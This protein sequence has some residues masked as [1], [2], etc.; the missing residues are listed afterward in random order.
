MAVEI[1][2]P[3][4]GDGIAS[5]DVLNVLVKEGDQIKKDQGIIELETGKAT[6]EVP[7]THEGKIT[8]VLVAAGQTI[9]IGAVLITL[10]ASET[11]TKPA[12]K[13]ATQPAAKAAT[14]PAGSSASAPA[15][16]SSA[17][18]TNPPR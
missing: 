13:G 10:E 9:S 11:A 14:K 16:K 1:K 2:L 18:H 8:K 3:N 17:R 6:F 7:S 4:L 5:G 12:A 15:G